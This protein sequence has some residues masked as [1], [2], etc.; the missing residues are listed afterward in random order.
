L[1]AVYPWTHVLICAILF[2]CSSPD[3]TAGLLLKICDIHS[4]LALQVAFRKCRDDGVVAARGTA[5][6]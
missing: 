3:P 6:L 5:T 2:S 1:Q 4:L